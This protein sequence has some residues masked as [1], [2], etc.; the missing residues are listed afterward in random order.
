MA[1]HHRAIAALGHADGDAQRQRRELRRILL[2]NGLTYISTRPALR[3]LLCEYISR[4]LP[5]RRVTCAEK[6]GWHN[7]VYVLPDEVIGPDGD[8]VILG[9]ATT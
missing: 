1:H 7:G 3:S 2:E 8:N 5:G 9:A 4:S 6:T